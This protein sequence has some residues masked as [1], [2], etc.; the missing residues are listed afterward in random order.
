MNID[1]FKNKNIHIVGIS[2]SEGSA[3]LSF[4]AKY[5]IKNITLHDFIPSK[6]LEKNFKLWHKGIKESEKEILWNKFQTNLK[7]YKCH[8]GDDYLKDCENADIIFVPQSWRLY[9]RNSKLLEISQNTNIPFYSLTRL[10]LEFSKAKVVGITG[11]V[12]KGSVAHDLYQLL[13]NQS[14][15][16]RNIFFAGNE[17]WRLQVADKLDQMTDN[18][19]LILEISHRQLLDGITRG[20][21]VAIFTNLYP[22]HLDEISWQEYKKFKFSLFQTQKEDDISILNFDDENI[23]EVIPFLKSKIIYYSEKNKDMNTKNIQNIFS[24]IL[25]TKSD[26]Y[27]VNIIAA[28]TAA[29]ILGIDIQLIKQKISTLKSLPARKELIKSIEGIKIY[30][31]IKSTTPW[32][33]LKAIKSLGKHCIVICGADMKD[34]DYTE[35]LRKIED[36]IELLIVIKSPLSEAV[37]KIYQGNY[38]TVENLS[39]AVSIAYKSA[40]KGNSILVSPAAA[41]FYTKFIAKKESLRKI[42]TSFPP[43]EKV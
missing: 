22:N 26:H 21:K 38:Q 30:D 33:T 1:N 40:Q 32:A 23:K 35:F 4:L 2:G 11:T 43:K 14:G 25:N 9:N 24:D 12:G 17:T 20:P 5:N 15:S 6:D 39:H 19:I 42:V 27:P 3:I 34:I 29:D 10:Y 16:K 13:R 8:F 37:K 41:F 31:D 18:D 28:S 36:N 7:N